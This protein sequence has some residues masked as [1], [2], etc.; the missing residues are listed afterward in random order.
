M[1]VIDDEAGIAD[2]VVDILSFDDHAVDTA[3]NGREALTR[4]AGGTYDAILSDLRM[5]ELDGE[6]L[7]RTLEEQRP[8][9]LARLAFI[10]GDTLG[11]ETAVFLERVHVPMLSKPFTAAEVRRL[12]QRVLRAQEGGAP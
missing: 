7:Y 12:V 4:L 9:L 2:L 5:P 11:P 8:E 1:L 6:T 10:T 3:A